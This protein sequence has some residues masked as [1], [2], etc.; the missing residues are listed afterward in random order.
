MD[1]QW[2]QPQVTPVK[3]GVKRKEPEADV[4]M[5]AD[6]Q[7]GSGIQGSSGT[8]SGEHVIA[9]PISRGTQE[10]RGYTFKMRWN[11]LMYTFGQAVT[12]V[13]NTAGTATIAAFLHRCLYVLNPAH[14]GQYCSLEDLATLNG[15]NELGF[16]LKVD[17]I[18]G[19]ANYV[20]L[21]APYIAGA[22][23]QQATASQTTLTVFK[24]RGLE[25]IAPL[26]QGQVDIAE[27]TAV[28]NSWNIDAQNDG[29]DWNAQILPSG[30]TLPTTTG[31]AVAF[32]KGGADANFVEYTTTAG[33]LIGTTTGANPVI[34][35]I[36]IIGTEMDVIDQT[37]SQGELCTWDHKMDNCFLTTQIINE[38]SAISN[39][40]VTVGQDILASLP[41]PPSAAGGSLL[42]LRAC[43]NVASPIINQNFY[44]AHNNVYESGRSDPQAL[45]LPPKEY[46]QLV[47]P[48]TFENG[49][50]DLYLQVVLDTTLHVTAMK[51]HINSH[52]ART[53]RNHYFKI[54]K[55]KFAGDSNSW[56][57]G[58]PVSQINGAIP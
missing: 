56:F 47:G 44:M 36:P 19:K 55:N 6:G 8:G 57:N 21:N 30:G 50:Q 33:L 25:R 53:Q 5:E 39:A 38:D 48:K 3:R 10:M 14:L 1:L 24:K 52:K 16:Q 37:K 34:D 46:I 40:S 31:T 12:V 26:Y 11:L 17:S 32:S 2:E 20:G 28:L 51:D 35:N 42:S 43:S 41:N 4:Q 58:N 45:S 22:N 18:H 29:F 49:T 54:P 23:D 7:G 13:R 15:L 9:R 27:K